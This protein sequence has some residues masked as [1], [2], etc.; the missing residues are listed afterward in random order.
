[1][2]TNGVTET[3]STEH[4][5]ALRALPLAR[6]LLDRLLVFGATAIAVIFVANLLVSL[7]GIC[8]VRH[9]WLFYADNIVADAK[10][11]ATGH[12]PYGNPATQF[13]G[14]SYTPLFTFVFAGLLKIYWWEGW[15]QVLSML[16]IAVSMAALIHMMWFAARRWES[17]LVTMS[18]VVAV[19]FG[20]LT[21][22]SGVYAYGVDQLAW[23][24]LVIA[25]TIT[26]RGLLSPE[27]LSGRQMVTTGLLLTGSVFSKQT[28]IVPCVV[29]SGLMIVVPALVESGRTWTWRK[30]FSSATVLMTFVG[31]S[32]LFGIALQV[33]SRGWAF[34]LL[35]G[36][37]LRYARFTPIGSQIRQSLRVLTLPLAALVVLAVC[38]TCSLLWAQ[39]EPNRRRHIVVA[40]AA[41]V[42]AVSPIPTAIIAEAKLGGDANQ[43]AGPVWTLTL[44]CAVLLLVLRPSVRHVAAAALA[45]GVL[46]AGIDP[47][48]HVIPGPPDLHDAQ[49]TWPSMDPFLYAAV[50][51]GEAVFDQSYPSLS[52]SPQAPAYPAGD[53]DDILAAGYTPRWFT[54]NLL[55][56]RY[57][58]VRPFYAFGSTTTYTSDEARY[59]GSVLW[60]YNLLLRMGYTTVTDPV[61]GF[62]YYRPSPRLKKLGWFAGCFGPYQSRG[63]QVD[64][65]LRGAGGLVC[66]DRGGL[67]LAQAPLSR[68]VFVL[69][70]GVGRGAASVRFPRTPHTLIVAPL[71]GNDRRDSFASDISRPDSAVASCLAQDGTLHT[72]TLRAVPGRG[73]VTCR[74]T[75]GQPVLAVPVNIGG[76]T[77]HVS[78]TLAVADTPTLVATSGK[79]RPAPFTLLNLT[80]GDINSL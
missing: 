80:P 26:F 54:N 74:T 42:F 76:S 56:G 78:M 57:A 8:F 14:Y 34:D 30:W 32:V 65:R 46:L 52:V 23:C 67:R 79:G 66:I 41:V 43:L 6:R 10:A 60:K 64:V 9:P 39:P 29:V 58:L 47:L 59:D 61:S 50:D 20:G 4:A 19:S 73:G 38:V 1:M 22:L 48:S 2:S 71:D 63:A 62:V 28:T 5:D 44:G 11:V 13:V 40:A 68:T 18:F 27:G 21:A 33:A 70:L 53:I 75:G 77:A 51:R 72:L 35:V 24:L 17:R 45:C 16:A 49:T 15:E 12:L 25:G 7:I 3:E 31:S 36:D 69:T 37:P 55:T